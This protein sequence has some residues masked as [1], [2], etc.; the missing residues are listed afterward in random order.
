MFKHS[1]LSFAC[2]LAMTGPVF[3]AGAVELVSGYEVEANQARELLAKAVSAYRKQGDT[4]LAQLSRQGAYTTPSTYVY[5]VSTQ[6]VMLASGGP[7]AIYIGRDIRPMLDDELRTALNDALSSAEDDVTHSREYHWMNWRDGKH[8][9]K[10][11]YFQRVGDKVFAAGYYMPRSSPQEA[12]RLLDDAVDAL[13][14][15]THATLEKINRLD[16]FYNR[17]DL[18]V[19]VIDE[20]SHTF[21]AHGAD[22]RLVGDDVSSLRG[23][24][25]ELIGPRL[26]SAVQGREEGETS[27]E[28]RN[29]VT[30]AKELKHTLM[31][32][33][34][35]FIVAVGYYKGRP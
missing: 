26:L 7:S 12:R 1:A 5:V 29:P 27:Y 13:R 25:G 16:A 2:L 9:R 30:G 35:N 22:H 4:V 17:D 31:R 33:E 8:E 6:G 32:R 24:N 18:Y 14:H 11:V 10:R 19:F 34:G 15:D 3:G 20:K 28:W 21:V 23:A